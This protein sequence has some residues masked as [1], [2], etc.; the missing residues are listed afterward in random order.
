MSKR[1]NNRREVNTDCIEPVRKHLEKVLASDLFSRAGSLSRFLRFVVERTLE[2]QSDQIKEYTLGVEVFGRGDAFDPKV[3]TI[4]RVQARKLRA[5][6]EKYYETAHDEDGVRI[7]LAPGSYVP[8]FRVFDPLVEPR[9][10]SR[11]EEGPSALPRV[12]RWLFVAAVVSAVVATGVLAWMFAPKPEPRP[13]ALR[14]VPL[15]AFV[16]SEK[17][18]SLSPDSRQVAFS[19]D[20]EKEDNFDIYTK[21]VGQGDPV[22][23]TTHPAV[24]SRPAWSP[25][26][27][28][29]AFQRQVSE[30]KSD[31]L[32]TRATGGPERKV[33]E[34][35]GQSYQFGMTWSPDSLWLAMTDCPLY[36]RCSIFLVSI[37][38]GEKRRLTMPPAGYYGD[39]SP[40]FSPDGRT[41][42]FVRRAGFVTGELYLLSLANDLRQV[43]E[44]RPLTEENLQVDQLAWTTD[45]KALL[46]VMGPTQG[47]TRLWKV[48]VSGSRKPELIPAAE[49]VVRSVAV[50]RDLVYTSVTGDGNVWRVSASG[51][52][53]P[54]GFLTSTRWDGNAEYSPDGKRIA[55]ISTRTGSPELWVCDADGGNPQPLT[56]FDE[57]TLGIPAWSPDGR[58]IVFHARPRGQADIFQVRAAGGDPKQLTTDP[59]DE[60][61]ARFS[62]DGRWIYFGSRRSGE[63]QIWKMPAMGGPAQQVTQN[64]GDVAVESVDGRFLYY[65]RASELLRMPLG[66]RSEERVIEG[67][68]NVSNF[69]VTADGIFWI[70]R[71]TGRGV[72]IRFLEFRGGLTRV[73]AHI[74]RPVGHAFSVSPDQRWILFTQADQSGSDLMLVENFCP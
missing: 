55:F 31:V 7:D 20:G 17:Q 51:G 2:G 9:G 71:E 73:I 32:I 69:Q 49:G 11:R 1:A 8:E 56:S 62:R 22:R 70:A 27:R 48:S 36:D 18:P 45:G 14:L 63:K 15:T 43:G 52:D 3:D 68:P 53:T 35:L 64:G 26:G 61:M 28:L 65:S 30:F 50:G 46:L 39:F 6:L 12:R 42:G 60:T 44:P 24:D 38:S 66:G 41:L 5:K 47:S 74:P 72:T 25:D 37:A 57:P 34:V 40:A 10:V 33:V 67:M 29:I 19:W 21:Q 4:V 59:S 23:L 58:Q 13:T 54:H 16:G